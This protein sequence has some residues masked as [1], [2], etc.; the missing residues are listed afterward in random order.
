M[1]G[2]MKNM[3][4]GSLALALA[5]PAFAA[6]APAAP[7]AGAPD[8]TKMGPMT[9]KVTKEDKKGVDAMYKAMEE[10][11]KKGDVN[12]AADFNDFPVLMVTDDSKGVESHSEVTRDNWV[13]MMEPFIKNMP[14]DMK[15]T[16][17]RTVHFLS[18]DLAFVDVDENMT[19]GKV[20]GSW[21]AES[22]LVRKDGKWKVKL[23]AEAGWGDMKMPDAQAAGGAAPAA[24]AAP[25]QGGK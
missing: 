20:K 24:A 11:M 8:M 15:T 12:A 14:K 6:D 18:D 3:L 17:K 5:V 10:A 4:I 22:M 21:H 25:A 9:R 16:H 7:A 2:K 13:K 23:D 1:E 19:M